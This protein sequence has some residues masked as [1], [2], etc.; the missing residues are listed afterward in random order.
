MTGT[1]TASSQASDAI[2]SKAG[3]V[4]RFALSGTW[5]G[6][7]LLERTRHGTDG[8][9]TIREMY[10]NTDSTMRTMPVGGNQ[11]YRLR[12]LELVS[13]TVDYTLE[14]STGE[15]VWAQYL[16]DGTEAISILDDGSLYL[17]GDLFSGGGGGGITRV[18]TAVSSPTLAG[19]SEDTD[20]IYLVSGTTTLTL[21]S[22][23]ANTNFYV[24]KNV[25]VNTVTIA[26][27]SAQTI[28]GSG[29]ASMPVPNTSLTLV[30][31]G[32]NWN[33]I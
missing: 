11:R 15:K 12:V 28:D 17:L 20:Y 14:R 23:V 29:T 31:D 32:A 33:V 24:I 22:A 7:V 10:S 27:S 8:W 6:I 5:T 30:S 13:G 21:P 18:V 2:L 16:L 19:N 3:E 26:T 1:F 9:R 25:G 4:I